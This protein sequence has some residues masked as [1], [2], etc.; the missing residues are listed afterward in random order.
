MST[1]NLKLGLVALVIVAIFVCVA[2][3]KASFEVAIPAVTLIVGT[4]VVALGIKASG[5][6][7][8]A[9]ALAVANAT[10]TTTTSSVTPA[11]TTNVTTTA[12]TDA[13]MKAARKAVAA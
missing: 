1:L 6:S 11:A 9:A 10:T 2:L 3:G 13:H 7:Q 5:D 12:V 8:A 4:L